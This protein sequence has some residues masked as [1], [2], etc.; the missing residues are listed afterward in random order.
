MYLNNKMRS[1]L[2]YDT[3]EY[4]HVQKKEIR[5][6]IDIR[7]T[8]FKICELTILPVFTYVF[9]LMSFNEITY[10]QIN[11]MHKSRNLLS[12]SIEPTVE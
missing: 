3:Q 7:E 8:L 6:V 12:I 5:I 9:I 11:A 2:C 1:R 10:F 4:L